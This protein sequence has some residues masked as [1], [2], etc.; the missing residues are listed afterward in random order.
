M[1][2]KVHTLPPDH[3]FKSP[4]V[5]IVIESSHGKTISNVTDFTLLHLRYAEKNQQ[6]LLKMGTTHR[7]VFKENEYNTFVYGSGSPHY[8]ESLLSLHPMSPLQSYPPNQLPSLSS[9]NHGFYFS[10]KV[11]VDRNRPPFSKFFPKSGLQ[12]ISCAC[13]CWQYSRFQV[14]Y[15]DVSYV[16]REGGPPALTKPNVMMRS[17]RCDGHGA[18]VTMQEHTAMITMRRPRCDGRDATV[19]IR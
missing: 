1:L 2:M 4:Q 14:A 3:R 11:L 10:P 8:F 19:T 17:S 9:H 5:W 13:L 12:V 6:K 7:W 16:T 18:M 15:M